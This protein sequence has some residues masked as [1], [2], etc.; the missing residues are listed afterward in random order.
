MSKA[1]RAFEAKLSEATGTDFERRNK[2]MKFT[3][4]KVNKTFGANNESSFIKDFEF[5]TNIQV[6]VHVDFSPILAV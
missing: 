4:S 6:S 5:K 3:R 2:L 1:K